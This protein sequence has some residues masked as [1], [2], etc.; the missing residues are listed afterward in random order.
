MYIQTV[1]G[2]GMSLNDFSQLMGV[3][4]VVMSLG[5][6]FNFDNSRE[7]VR[8]MS[9]SATARFISGMFPLF[10]GSWILITA[11]HNYSNYDWGQWVVIACA[12][13]MFVAG[14]FRLLFVA[15]WVSILKLYIDKAPI[16]AG[17]FGLIF[18][19]LLTYIGFI[20]PYI[21]G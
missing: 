15:W 11:C 4:L 18:G 14:I 20:R 16:F 3:I 1:G 8:E 12:T 17:L 10:F 2:N 13:L 5:I 21:L 7:L 6:L 9:E 19:L